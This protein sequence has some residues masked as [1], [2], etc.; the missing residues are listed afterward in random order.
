MLLA[1]TL[2][3][4]LGPDVGIDAPFLN[5][6]VG[7]IG[8]FGFEDVVDGLVSAFLV[9]FSVGFAVPLP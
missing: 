3:P 8:P 1:G 5:K 4:P 9:E 7:R 6:L 2:G